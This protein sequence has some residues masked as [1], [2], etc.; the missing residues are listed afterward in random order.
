[1]GIFRCAVGELTGDPEK[2]RAL[3]QGWTDF[4]AKIEEIRK[5]CLAAGALAPGW[6]GESRDSYDRGMDIE[7][8]DLAALV[9][10]AKESSGHLLAYSKVLAECK[11]KVS[12]LRKFNDAMDDAYTSLAPA[13]KA[14]TFNAFEGKARAHKEAYE[15]YVRQKNAAAQECAARLREALHVEKAVTIGD[16]TGKR[17]GLSAEQM[18]AINAQISSGKMG[19]RDINQ[20]GIADC[21][22]VANIMAV[23]DSPEG[24]KIIQDSIKLHYGPDGKP[25][26]FM[27]TVYDDPAH[28]MEQASRKVFV[29][30]VYGAGVTGPDGKPNYASVLESAY[31]QQHPGGVLSSHTSRGFA[32]G[33]INEASQDLTDRPSTRVEGIDGYSPTERQAIID[34]ANDSSRPV[35]VETTDAPENNFP[36]GKAYANVNLP[37]GSEDSIV[38]YDSHAY[39]VVG[40]N[41]EGVTLANPHGHNYAGDGRTVDGT[42]SMSWPEFDKYY[43]AAAIGSVK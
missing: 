38:L 41:E 19:Y 26:G 24:R 2:V 34:A 20:H 10:G 21:Y 23:V 25:D 1:M 33:S 11:E 40:A 42:F 37:D 27:V 32:Y 31:G 4:A 14:A 6:A 3:A 13:Q 30:D 15:S 22:Y 8:K 7:S 43:S 29:D 18:E 36:E 17:V 35:V 28:P 12:E 9:D 39:M 16:L 5:A